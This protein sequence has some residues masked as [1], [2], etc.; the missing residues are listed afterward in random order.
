VSK[1]SLPKNIIIKKNREFTHIINSG[2]A[3][4]GKYFSAFALKGKDIR[5]GFAVDREAANKPVKNKLKRIAREM[6][7][8]HFRAF[9]FKA[10][11]VLLVKNEACAK[12]YD[13]LLDDFLKICDKITVS[14]NK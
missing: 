9:E 10:H 13:L 8:K 11:V 6:W 5:I 4:H 12:K 1:Q 7:R 2:S 14:L 3:F